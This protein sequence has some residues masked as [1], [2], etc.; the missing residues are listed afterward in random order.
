MLYPLIMI[1]YHILKMLLEH[2]NYESNEN[3]RYN[4]YLNIINIFCRLCYGAKRAYKIE[5]V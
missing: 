4:I 3:S 1:L 2:G 5:K